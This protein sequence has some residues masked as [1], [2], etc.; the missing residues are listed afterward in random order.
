MCAKKRDRDSSDFLQYLKDEL[1]K[2][3]RHDL[4]KDL[5]ADAFEQEAMEG[6]E[7]IS[8]EKAEQ[9]ILSLHET[10]SRRLGR[11]RRRTWYSIAATAASILLVG[12]IFLNIYD[13]NPDKAGSEPLTEETFRDLD[14]N[15]EATEA[16]EPEIAP[17]AEK[18]MTVEEPSAAEKPPAAADALVQHEAPMAEKPV[19]AIAP[20]A[21]EP[22]EAEVAI[23]KEVAPEEES[24]DMVLE[25]E[26]IVAVEAE[27][28]RSKRSAMKEKMAAPMT[29]APQA[30]AATPTMQAE[31]IALAG[32][33]SGFVISSEDME[34]LPGANIMIRGTET[35]TLTDMEGRFTLPSDDDQTTVVASF[36]GMETEEYQLDKQSDNQLLMQPDA[37]MLDEVVVVASG[38]GRMAGLS[39]T[40]STRVV[41]E[42][43]PPSYSAAEPPEGYNAYRDYVEENM[44]FPEGYIPGEREI[45]VLKFTV[46]SSASISDII[47]LRS[48]GD[49]YTEEAKRLLLQGPKWK[50]AILKGVRMDEQVRIRIV[51]KK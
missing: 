42:E 30:E 1:S 2:Q 24:F 26:E 13:L 19:E 12:T 3:E 34:A 20:L 33:V 23:E 48:P 38:S 10:L 14:S 46:T 15:K 11:R 17:K 44:V 35:G 18:K 7:S 16:P 45:V 49:D 25:E 43:A 40:S 51:F 36:I 39:A 8:P 27:P 28:Q 29:N 6:L 22:P 32:Q 37:V 31:Q 9:D 4:E 50:S 21:V 5:Q 41:K 47:P